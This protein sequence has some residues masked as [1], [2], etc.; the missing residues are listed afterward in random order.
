[1]KHKINNLFTEWKEKGLKHPEHKEEIRNEAG[2]F[3]SKHDSKEIAEAL[4]KN[5]KETK[6]ELIRG[7][8]IKYLDWTRGIW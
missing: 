3:V 5:H 2:K 7:L 1:M 8:E 6:E 4:K